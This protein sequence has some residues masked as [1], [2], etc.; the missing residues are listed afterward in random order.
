MRNR[1][2]IHAASAALA[3]GAL[4]S[5]GATAPAIAVD[6]TKPEPCTGLAFT[7]APADQNHLQ[8]P[9]AERTGST[10][11][12][13]GFLKHDPAK[14]DEATTYNLTVASLSSEVPTGWTT[15]S[16]NLYYQPPGE[17]EGNYH[18]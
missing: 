12:I 13:N 2:K 15:Q 17:E 6:D 5:V 1:A 4:A 18:F 8:V 9:E 14:G 16:W 11:L 3:A 10:E 7:D